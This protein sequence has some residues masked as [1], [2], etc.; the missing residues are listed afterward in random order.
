[1][2]KSRRA[3]LNVSHQK[4]C[5]SFGKAGL[6]SLEACTCQP[7]YFTVYRDSAGRL[8]RGDDGTGAIVGRTRRRRD[9]E[10]WLARLLDR[11]EQGNADPDRR[12]SITFPK[13]VEE[14][15]QV[16]AKRVARGKLKARTE[17][18][19]AETLERAVETIGH[20]DVRLI[21]PKELERFADSYGDKVSDAT[22]G[23]RLR[24]LGA[25]LSEAVDAGYLE[26]NPVRL[27]VKKR[28]LDT[29]ARGKD[30]FTDDELTKLWAALAKRDKNGQ[31]VNGGADDVYL[32]LF[33]VAVATGA[34]MGELL[35]LTWDDVSLT[36]RRLYIRHTYNVL[37]GL[38]APKTKGSVRTIHLTA[39]AVAE[40]E[41]MAKTTSTGPVFVGPHGERVNKSYIARVLNRARIAAGVAKDGES[42]L[43][44]SFHS[45][46]STFDRRALE[47]GLHPEFVR[48]QLGHASLELTLNHYGRWSDAALQAEAAKATDAL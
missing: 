46:R 14:Y 11:L 32:H 2:A 31:P 24:E 21:G 20:I 33:R 42:G 15:K 6:D 26:R 13:W 18:D 35:A 25:C 43:P 23:R 41:A 28:E 39:A 17:R 9:A 48:A 38:T 3:A 10:R 16:V 34:R 19:Y 22:L 4:G 8:V 44:R 7:S 47:Q 1:M 30:P 40:L 12:E 5:P 27:Y 29:S 37:D 36:E 45:F